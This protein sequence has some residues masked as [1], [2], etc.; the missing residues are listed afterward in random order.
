MYL[1]KNTPL[2][3]GG[4]EY[5]PMTMSSEGKYKRRKEK[6]EENMKQNGGK[7]KKVKRIK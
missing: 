7:T 3:A 5:S 6:K 2:P 1:L 4:G